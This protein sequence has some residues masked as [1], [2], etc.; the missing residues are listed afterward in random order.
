MPSDVVTMHSR[1]RIVHAGTGHRQELTLSYPH[2]AK[3][4]VGLVSVLSPLGRALLGLQVG[5]VAHWASPGGGTFAAEV[6][7][8]LYQPEASGDLTA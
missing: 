7:E 1:V 5:A 8:L 4:A 2:E 6:A 3:P